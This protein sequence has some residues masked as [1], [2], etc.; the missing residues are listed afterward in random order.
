MVFPQHAA[1]TRCLRLATAKGLW[2]KIRVLPEPFDL[3]P[4]VCDIGFQ[5]RA[6]GETRHGTAVASDCQSPRRSSRRQRGAQSRD[7]CPHAA[8][9][10][11]PQRLLPP[12]PDKGKPVARLGRKAKGHTGLAGGGS[13][14]TEGTIELRRWRATV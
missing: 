1:F 9:T 11:R 13:L 2:T 4:V 12:I 6:K 5:Y 3:T 14:V 10:V 8:V 7:K